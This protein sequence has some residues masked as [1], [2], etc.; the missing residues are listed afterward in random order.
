MMNVFLGN[1]GTVV[2]FWFHPF[3]VNIAG[4]F[5]LSIQN[6]SLKCIDKVN[7]NQFSSLLLCQKINGM[8]PIA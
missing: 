2:T 7:N 8:H 3:R 6:I 4:F 1:R 5:L